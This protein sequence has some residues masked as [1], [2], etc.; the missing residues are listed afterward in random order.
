MQRI[1]CMHAN[2]RAL[3][4]GFK[5]LTRSRWCLLQPKGLDD[6]SPADFSELI[7]LDSLSAVLITD[8]MLARCH[9]NIEVA[10][11]VL[12]STK[13]AQYE[14][15]NAGCACCH[16]KGE[17]R[18]SGCHRKSIRDPVCL[19]MIVICCKSLVP[20]RILVPFQNYCLVPPVN[21]VIDDPSS[22]M[23][24]PSCHISI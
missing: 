20:W 5:L 6:D 7:Y 4:W 18:R 11:L 24:I 3:F 17:Q 1:C 10:K 13:P 12:D 15:W 2:L 23:R 8:V 16:E 9:T 21:C 14:R 19:Q 22:L